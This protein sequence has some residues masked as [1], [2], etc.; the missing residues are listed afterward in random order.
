[1]E[2]QGQ[3]IRSLL[4]M[5][6][7]IK[8]TGSIAIRAEDIKEPLG[9][10]FPDGVQVLNAAVEKTVP[11]FTFHTSLEAS[12]TALSYDFPLLNPGDEAY[13]AVYVYN[14]PPRQP[15]ARGRIVD[16]RQ[17]GFLDS[18]AAK[19]PNPFPYLPSDS[20]RRVAYWVLL[21]FNCSL[22]LV[23][24]AMFI[25]AAAELIQWRDW[26]KKW[27]DEYE[28]AVIEKE[29]DRKPEYEKARR[30]GRCKHPKLFNILAA[31]DLQAK[32]IPGHPNNTSFTTGV[33][34]L[35]R[36]T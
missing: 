17:I 32:S 30:E 33:M 26:L 22:A 18:S 29:P 13:V 19:Q 5:N 24:A 6:F 25:K 16:V 20:V 35:R 11:D 3:A 9:L 15:T 28:K 1:V 21:A 4:K 34:L 7:A 36:T 8:N 10:V 27:A 14:S 2:F 31:G 12:R 23:F